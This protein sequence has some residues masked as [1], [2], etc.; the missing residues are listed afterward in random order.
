MQTFTESSEMTNFVFSLKKKKI[1]CYTYMHIAMYLC[2]CL[3][4][5]HPC[6]C[7]HTCKY[8]HVRVYE[9][10]QLFLDLDDVCSL[11][12][13]ICMHTKHAYICTYTQTHTRTHARIKVTCSASDNLS[14]RSWS[15]CALFLFS[16]SS[17]L[18]NSI[19]SLSR[20]AV[21]ALIWLLICTYAY[22]NTYCEYTW[23][24]MYYVYVCMFM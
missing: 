20:V 19:V 6:V 7:V 9:H 24:C 14:T 15:T 3:R 18:L 1:C 10:V 17:V 23:V 5:E 4:F 22:T 16:S 2:A 13:H 21:R 8:T 12:A 11:S